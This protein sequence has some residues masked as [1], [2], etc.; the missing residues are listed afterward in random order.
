MIASGI[1]IKGARVNV[2]GL[3]FKEDC[4]DLRNSK[5]V[6]IIRELQ[7]YGVEVAVSDPRA[8][9]SE[10]LREYGLNLLPWHELPR[11]DALVAA[12]A[13]REFTDMTVQDMG[14][15]LV[16]G[17]SF[18]DVKSAFDRSAILAAGYQ[19]WRL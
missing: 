15:K 1:C 17:G 11:A 9:A 2:L 12:V 14:D 6:D 3:T 19:L 7:D 5:V 10:A 16:S 18:I 8:E 13:H 4:G